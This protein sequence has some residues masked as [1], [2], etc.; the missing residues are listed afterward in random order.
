LIVHHDANLL[1]T[2]GVNRPINELN[3]SELP[4]MLEEYQS[5]GG[6]MVK[7]QRNKLLLLEDLFQ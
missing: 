1:R 7:T 6:G 3:H 5:F 4:N 2:C